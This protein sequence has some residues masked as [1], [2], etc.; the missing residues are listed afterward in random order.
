MNEQ[1]IYAHRIAERD[2]EYRQR[3]M[4]LDLAGSGSCDLQDPLNYLQ[5]LD[6]A[7]GDGA[8]HQLGRESAP[9]DD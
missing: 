9:L 4:E 6:Q 3:R 1:Q 2:L 8:Q 5:R 7:G